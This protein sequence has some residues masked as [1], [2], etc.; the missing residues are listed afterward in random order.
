MQLDVSSVCLIIIMTFFFK[1]CS[2]KMG[3]LTGSYV[4]MSFLLLLLSHTVLFKFPAFQA[5][6]M[7]APSH[8]SISLKID[9]SHRHCE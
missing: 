9:N 3:V 1:A 4:L 7:K 5:R 6:K 8:P 2:S